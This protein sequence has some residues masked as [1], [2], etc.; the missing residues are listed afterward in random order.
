VNNRS[1]IIEQALQLFSTRGYDAVGIQ[2]IVDKAK[3]TKPTLYHY[4]GS[5]EGLLKSLLEEHFNRM[6]REISPAVDY[7]GD[8]TLTLRGIVSAYFGFAK[9]NNVFY[10]MQLTLWFAPPESEAKQSVVEWNNQQYKMVEKVFTAAVKEHGNMKGRQQYYAATFIGM[11]N[12]YIGL[13][14]NKYTE[15]SEELVYQLV[16][17]FMHGIL[18]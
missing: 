7:R 16:H 6:N 17:Q 15:L 1:K 12:T 10:R 18:S 4:F 13:Y 5:K 8:L 14:L 2:E 11:I 3:I 9:R